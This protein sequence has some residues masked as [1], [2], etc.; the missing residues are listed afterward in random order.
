MTA[1]LLV[2]AA[3]SAWVLATSWAHRPRSVAPE[4]AGLLDAAAPPSRVIPLLVRWGGRAQARVGVLGEL[5]AVVVG[6]A[7]SC[8]AVVAVVAPRTGLAIALVVVTAARTRSV[9][10]QRERRRRM[11][12]QAPAVVDLLCLCL[13]AGMSPRQAVVDVRDAVDAPLGDDL[14]EV[15]VRSERG[16]PLALALDPLTVRGHPLRPVAL[17][18]AS[19]E[20]TGV[21]LAGSLDRLAAEARAELR[22]AGQERARRLPVL[23]LLPL[24][25]CVLPAFVLVAIVPMLA[26]RLGGLL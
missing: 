15:V 5:P 11:T 25:F 6:V 20:R 3:W 1:P 2:A 19:A 7:M 17:A 12:A 22:R 18:V 23:M 8:V 13:D 16:E 21:P 4:L 9:T 26:G 14:A 24:V 10:R